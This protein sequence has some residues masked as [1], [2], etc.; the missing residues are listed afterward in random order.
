MEIRAIQLADIE[1]ESKAK[2]QERVRLFE[3]KKEEEKQLQEI[4]DNKVKRMKELAK[5]FVDPLNLETEIE[6]ALNQRISYEFSIDSK[7]KRL[8]ADND[9]P[10]KI[11]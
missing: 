1:L 9:E 10:P 7:G 6:K 4:A 2:E 3:R 11:A 5:T 8:N